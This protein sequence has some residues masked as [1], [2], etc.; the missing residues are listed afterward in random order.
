LKPKIKNDIEIDSKT[1][2][3]NAKRGPERRIKAGQRRNRT[4]VKVEQA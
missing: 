3:E 2:K 4:A 1:L